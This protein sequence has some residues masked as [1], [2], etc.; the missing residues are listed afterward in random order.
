MLTAQQ[1]PRWTAAAFTT[2]PHTRP[3]SCPCS[4][5]ARLPNLPKQNFPPSGARPPRT[6]S[7]ALE[8]QARS[9]RHLPACLQGANKASTH[10]NLPPPHTGEGQKR[11][12]R[13]GDQTSGRLPDQR[14]TSWRRESIFPCG[15]YW[16]QSGHSVL[17][18]IPATRP[19]LEWGDGRQDQRDKKK[20]LKGLSLCVSYSKEMPNMQL[21][22]SPTSRHFLKSDSQRGQGLWPWDGLWADLIR[23]GRWQ[24][25]RQWQRALREGKYTNLRGG[26]A[27]QSG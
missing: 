5:W 10:K 3:N 14:R 18:Q 22:C 11:Q 27:G 8:H 17:V 15:L 21:Q 23:E 6:A 9:S 16:A 25:Q 20:N 13:E 2:L 26:C 7:R 24:F 1:S 4:L 12:R 19:P